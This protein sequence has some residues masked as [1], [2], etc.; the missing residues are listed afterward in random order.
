MDTLI[1]FEIKR[2]FN[3]Y[4]LA[5]YFIIITAINFA[6]L[7]T[8]AVNR[9]FVVLPIIFW[10]TFLIVSIVIMFINDVNSLSK[11]LFNNTKYFTASLPYDSRQK[12][13]AKFIAST[14]VFAAYSLL[15]WVV[16]IIDVWSFSSFINQQAKINLIMNKPT[17]FSSIFIIFILGLAGYLFSL[18]A[19]YFPIILRKAFRY[20]KNR[21]SF[22]GFLLFILELD[23]IS[24][25]KNILDNI[26]HKGLVIKVPCAMNFNF[27]ENSFSSYAANWSLNL[28]H[29]VFFLAVFLGLFLLSSY[30]L[31]KEIDI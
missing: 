3:A 29:V 26:F 18:M 30:L 11:D 7:M 31:D 22:L 5:L 9:S 23:V 17:I 25:F 10:V 24:L 2:K 12:L 21:G 13:S 20:N 15:F 6:L 27:D 4:K 14:V 28:V 1:S 19:V 16:S 8:S